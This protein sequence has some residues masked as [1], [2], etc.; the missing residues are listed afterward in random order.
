MSRC[1]AEVALEKIAAAVAHFAVVVG[2]LDPHLRCFLA[3]TLLERCGG[4]SAL[5][6]PY[7]GGS[8]AY[9]NLVFA[10]T[11]AWRMMEISDVMIGVG[12]P[13]FNGIA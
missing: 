10:C 5:V 9:G 1:V 8:N 7:I 12:L 6:F 2:A 13:T 3:L 4:P 11:V